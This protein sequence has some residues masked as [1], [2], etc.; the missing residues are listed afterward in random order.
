MAKGISFDIS[1]VDK[2]TA[3]IN[4]INNSVSKM[5][6]PY[7][8]LGKSM[9]QFTD[10][11][12]LNKLGGA[13]G[14]VASKAGSV[15]SSFAKI[16]APLLALVGGGT[17][18]GLVEMVSTFARMGA[19][20]ERTSTLLGI[21]AQNLNAM[22][23]AAQLMGVS[24]D[25]MTSGFK[26]LADTLQDARWGRNQAAYIGLQAL[27]ITLHET[28]AGAIDT[29]QAMLDLSDRITQIQKVDPAAARNLARMFGVENLLPMLSKGSVAMRKYQEEAKRLKGVFTPEMAARATDFSI[30]TSKMMMSIEGMK[31]SISDKLMPII[32]PLIEQ[33][34]NWIAK[35]REFISTK[36]AEYAGKLA[37]MLD[38]VDWYEFW[39]GVDASLKAVG[40]LSLKLI[41]FIDSIGGVKTLL[42]A[43]GIY[44]G[45]G[46]VFS[47]IATTA[48]V[49]FL[50]KAVAGLDLAL[51]PMLG[52]LE[53][54][55]FALSK[56][57]IQA[58]AV[59]KVLEFLDPNDKIGALADKYIP[60]AS[61]IDNA[62]SK[63][64]MGRSY[65]QQNLPENQSHA[66]QQLMGMGWSKE[67]AAGL[68]ANFTKE[69]TFNSEAVGDNGHAYGI[70]QWHED[71]Q[72]NFKRWAGKDIRGSSLDEQLGFANYELTQGTE[73]SAGN[74]LRAADNSYDAGSLV[75]SLYE[76]PANG[77]KE[78]DERGQIAVN[79]QNTVNIDKSGNATITTKTPSTSKVERVMAG[80]Y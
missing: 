21:S 20:L 15:A 39:N 59:H 16:G 6:R 36:I 12:G 66:M 50:V 46:F 68:V 57:A 45:T 75:S 71:R 58:Y 27:G 64:G 72:E 48:Q 49:V 2:A 14:N 80:A 33:F 69:S 32:Q 74:K 22:R 4:K 52:K 77:I 47:M 42:I 60:G 44:L 13:L 23:G 10:V 73:K 79:V 11:S 29:E 5:T 41:S 26:S 30:A 1:A 9:K 18:A 8:N 7:T 28:K 54:V 65:A 35:N 24:G 43:L 70:G 37:K 25:D 19:E 34:T 53:A 76:R 17:I 63:I 38:G 62:A 61:F 55:A 3:T 67:Q 40:S 51:I 78:A 56:I 31:T